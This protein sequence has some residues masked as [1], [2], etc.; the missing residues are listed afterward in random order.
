MIKV[1]LTGNIACGKSAVQNI[2]LDMGY[3]VL[4]ADECAHR[5]LNENQEVANIFGTNDRRT[6][7]KIVFADKSK[8]KILE[9]IIHPLVKD[10]IQSF[11]SINKSRDIVFVAVPQLFEAGF[12]GLFDKI[13]LVSAPYET[14][15]QRLISRNNYT[16]GYAKLRLD[17]Q[18]DES[19][20]IP[21]CD[22][23]ILNN[24]NLSE[25]E[26]RTKECLKLLL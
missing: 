4:D 8:L 12:E 26:K 24:S 19:L 3:L 16:E 13:I 1:A 20:K 14:R 6:L 21:Y 22:C 9:D 25:L 2:L 5:V 15:L 17:S 11:F 10:K 18:M 7:A 23:I